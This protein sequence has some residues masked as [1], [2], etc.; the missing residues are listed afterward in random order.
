MI[1]AILIGAGQRGA[2]V[3]G[4]YARKHPEE[5]KVV[6]VA[7]PLEERRTECIQTHGISR[8]MAFTDWRDSSAV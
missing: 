6:A 3:Y 5:F 4:E 2:F 8:D 7:E 1:T